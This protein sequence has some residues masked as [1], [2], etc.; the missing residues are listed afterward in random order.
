MTDLRK[1][2]PRTLTLRRMAVLPEFERVV[3]N[4]RFDALVQ[5]LR[6]Q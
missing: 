6:Q 3:G 2:M 1:Y 5:E 4:P